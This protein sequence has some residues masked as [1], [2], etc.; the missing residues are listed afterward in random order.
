[1]STGLPLLVLTLFGALSAV[2]FVGVVAIF[3]RFGTGLPS[4]A[5][6][7]RIRFSQESIVYD[8]T[9]KELARFSL[10]ERR[11]TAPYEDLP[12]ILIDATTAVEDKTFWTNTGFDPLGIVAAGIDSL[13]GN[14]RGASTIT[15]QLVRQ[16]L[17]PEDVVAGASLAERKIRE[18]VQSVRVTQAYP[19]IAGKERILAAYLNQNFYGNNSYGVRTAARGYF[20]KP[21]SKLTV[22]QAAILAALPQSPSTYDLVRNAIETEPGDPRCGPDDADGVCLVVPDDTEIVRRRN[23]ILDLLRDPARRVLTRDIVSV[24]DL[25]AAKREPVVLSA[26]GFPDWKAPHFVWLVRDQVRQALC[27][28][29]ETCPRLEEGGLR[30]TTT[31]DLRLQRIA[32]KWVQAATLVPHR[33]DPAE[34]AAALNVPYTS[35]MA[36]L[37]TKNVWNGAAAAIDYQTGEIIAYVGSANYYESRRVNKRIQPQFDVLS[38]GWRQ[39]GS[40]FKPFNY[41]TGIDAR[42]L[43]ASSMLM[44]VVTDFGRG[45][46]PSDFDGYERGPLRLR[47]ALQQSLNIPSVKALLW[48]GIERV[49]AMSQAMGMRFLVGAPPGPSMALG[50]LEV[51]PIDLVTAYAT[52]ANG[53]RYLGHAAILSVKDV[54]GADV[55]PP[56]TVPDGSQT[57][58]AASAYVITDILAGNTDPAENP[59]WGRM[60]I[61]QGGVRRPATLKTGTNNDAKDLNAYGY[62]APPTKAG[63][64][65]GEYALALGVWAGNSDNTEVSTPAAPVV[66]LDVAGPMWQAIL[67]E[68]TKGWA[69]N[70]FQ[71]PRGLVTET[72]DAFTGFRPSAWSKRQVKE[73]FLA[74]N[75]PGDDPYLRPLYVIAGPDG[76]DY[77]WKEQCGGAPRARGYLV[78]NQA[79]AAFPSW[80]DAVGGWIRRARRGIGVGGNVDPDRTTYTMYY[81]RPGYFPYGSSWG[82]PFPPADWCTEAPSPGP[83]LSPLPSIGPLPSGEPTPTEEPGPE[84]TPKPEKTAKPTAPPTEPPP[85]PEPATPEPPPASPGG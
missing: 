38:D 42:T 19:G 18:I 59:T 2:L 9:G 72:V 77:K 56:Y 67:T 71:R 3:L 30:I 83:S 34:S 41:V 82:G 54:N 33:Q 51:H 26:Q 27:G 58:S 84:P 50:T 53:G 46:T 21:L 61:T 28:D 47:L 73:L 39:P 80:N 37:R 48:T 52:L 4:P 78:L 14:A 35:W 5:E 1:M 62:I 36:N 43:T 10:G 8:R 75:V 25:D 16:R 40:A 66:S 24:A 70:D 20:G 7:E 32:E 57:V 60:A 65:A 68:M 31:L 74:D 49:F 63:R 76:R 11:E 64:E 15:Q 44:D 81:L 23:Y 12:P 22:A 55:I 85:T 13:R 79:E 69:V 29:A 6:L 17:L 45:Y